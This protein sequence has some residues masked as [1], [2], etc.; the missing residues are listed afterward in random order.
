MNVGIYLSFKKKEKFKFR[1]YLNLFTKLTISK[2]ND[3]DL[4]ELMS[5]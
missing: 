4:I 2:P 3:Y 1:P 5:Q